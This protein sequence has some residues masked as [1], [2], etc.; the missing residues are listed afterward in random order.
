[1]G[2]ALF[3]IVFKGEVGLDFDQEEVKVNLQRQCGFSPEVVA[4]LFSGGSFVL[5][6]E[7]DEETANR[8]REMLQRLGALCE[9]APMIPPVAVELPKPP[10][11]FKVATAG[12]PEEAKFQCPACQRPQPKGETCIACGVVFAKLERVQARRAA[13]D[14]SA[15]IAPVAPAASR[16]RTAGSRGPETPDVQTFLLW[17]A[18]VFSGMAVLQ[19]LLAK[20][21][22]VLGFILLPIGLLLYLLYRAMSTGGE[23]AE[24]LEEAA[25]LLPAGEISGHRRFPYV[26]WT[27]AFLQPLLFYLLLPLLNPETVLGYLTFLPLEQGAGHVI[28]SLF[29]ALVLHADGWQLW[30]SVLLLWVVGSVVETRLGSLRFVGAYLLCGMVASGVGALFHPLLLKTPLHAVGS[31]GAIAG[32]LG[33]YAAC[34]TYPSMVFEVPFFGVAARF[35]AGVPRIG[36]NALVVIGIFVYANLFGAF[37][38]QQP[39]LTSIVGHLAHVGGFAVGI[40]I[41]M[42]LD[43]AALA[44][45]RGTAELAPRRP[46]GSVAQRGA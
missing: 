9:I 37:D 1:M 20:G 29:G 31:S 30:G 40:L 12:N 22:S 5:K 17:T 28:S 7:I 27:L 24:A 14:A 46:Q 38:P 18:Y 36:L 43:P 41:G 25:T 11:A 15:P 16:F 42:F 2:N 8:Y 23:F 21:L 19:M 32:L 34:C 33:I 4:K 45:A 6:K 26:T 10:E 39:W 35:A 13:E 3:K 44:D